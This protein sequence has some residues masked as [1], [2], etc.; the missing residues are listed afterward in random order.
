MTPPTLPGLLAAVTWRKSTYG[1][2]QIDCVEVS[3]D[4]PGVVPVRD[5]RRPSGSALTFGAPAWG[6]FIT[7][8]KTD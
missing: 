2:A 6:S 5:S 8:I 7:K 4:M 3:D 1:Q